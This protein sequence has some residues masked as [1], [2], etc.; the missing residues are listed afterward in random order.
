MTICPWNPDDPR[1]PTGT[2]L[3]DD[4]NVAI[5]KDQ[6]AHD[7]FQDFLAKLE[8]DDVSDPS[9]VK[10]MRQAFVAGATYAMREA[11]D[12]IPKIEDTL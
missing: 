6:D 5:K 3:E 8:T 4:I 11:A 2:A 7:A 9:K 12:M 1:W 10:L